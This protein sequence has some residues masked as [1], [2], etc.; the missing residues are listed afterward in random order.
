MR[1]F[2]T[3]SVAVMFV[4]SVHA[5]AQTQDNSGVQRPV[6]QQ[7]IDRLKRQINED[8]RSG[9]EAVV[10]YHTETGDL[11]SRLDSFRYGGRF[12]L[13]L[14]PSSAIQL[15]GTRT[16]YMPITSV[17][18]ESGINFTASF[19]SKLSEDME[20]H[21]E[22]GATRFSTDTTSINALG[23][24]TYNLSE[25]ARLY[26]T[27]SRSNVEES[28]LSIAGIRPVTGPFAGQL[29]GRVMENRFVVGGSSRLERG[30]DVFGAGGVGTRA[31]SNV[32][33]NFFKTVGGGAGYSILA[34]AD[35]VP[36]SLLRAAYELNYS[37]FNDNRFGF[38]GASF[39]TRRGSAIDPAR[40][41][42][43]G[44]SPNPG[45]TGAGVGGYFSPKNFVSNIGRVE[46]K[47]A[48]G[49]ALSYTVSGFLGSQN[50]TGASGRLAQGLSGTVSVEL[51]ERISLPVTYFIDNFGPFT[52]QSL[53]ARLA[54]K[55]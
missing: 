46:A 10:D 32:P 20:A 23:S 12:N 26:A 39:L 14:G 18:G 3:V 4:F 1:T 33:S 15:T 52:Q 28:L 19:Q 50:Y 34:R 21:I 53:Y 37:G 11:N 16:S 13:R 27:A 43:D 25:G 7:E 5:A 35:D 47:G 55:F 30:F 22:A 6:R 31:G 40:I 29:V 42:S 17:F 51:T 36:L 44:I 45:G 48:I 54:V 49:D 8:T 2:V 41:G 24:V 9:V 38:G